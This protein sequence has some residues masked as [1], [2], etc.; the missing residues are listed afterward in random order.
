MTSKRNIERRVNDLAGGDGPEEIVIRES[1]VETDYPLSD[2]PG[3]PE[4]ETRLWCTASG[5]W[6]RETTDLREP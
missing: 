5:Q 2:T 6:R 1:I 3:G 4:R